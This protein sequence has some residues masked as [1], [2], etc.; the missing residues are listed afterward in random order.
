MIYNCPEQNNFP[1]VIISKEIS[2]KC[3]L[4]GIGPEHIEVSGTAAPSIIGVPSNTA[5]GPSNLI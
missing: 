3:G 4:P 1:Q 5:T 2:G